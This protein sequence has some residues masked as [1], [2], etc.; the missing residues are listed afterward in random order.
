MKKNEIVVGGTY[1]AKVGKNVTTVRV[2]AIRT[3]SG[4]PLLGP[5][6]GR[7]P[8]DVMLYRVTNLATN[9]KTTFR[10]AAKFRSAAPGKGAQNGKPAQPPAQDVLKEEDKLPPD[11]HQMCEDCVDGEVDGVRCQVCGG[12]G[13]VETQANIDAAYV[14]A[15]GEKRSDP[16]LPVAQSAD[17]SDMS[18]S[19]TNGLTPPSGESKKSAN[20]IASGSSASSTTPACLEA[21]SP[22][23]RPSSETA[24]TQ[25][26]TGAGA[27]IA[28]AHEKPTE[29]Q[30][31]V[32]PAQAANSLA[33]RLAASRAPS[34]AD[35]APHLIVEARAGCLSADTVININRAKKGS[36]MTIEKVVRQFTGVGAT[37][38]RSDNGAESRM[39]PWDVSI[40]TMVARAVGGVVRLG[41]IENAWFSGDKETYALTTDTGRSIH[42]TSIHPFLTQD[43]DWKKL[44]DIV[45]G[46]VLQVNVGRSKKGPGP[47]TYY[48]TLRTQ[49]HPSQTYRGNNVF[50]VPIHRA[51]VEADM[52]TLTLK[53]FAWIVKHD[54]GRSAELTYLPTTSI[55]HHKN[56]DTMDN[57]L[58][59]LE[60]LDS[61]KAHSDEH[62]WGNNVLWQIGFETVLSVEYFGVE[63]TYDIEVSDDP[64]NFL[65]NGF[66]VHNTGKTT[67]LIEGL[68]YVMGGTST[69]MPSPQQE[70]VWKEMARSAGKARSVCF[71]AF[72]KSIA[73][74]L[75]RRVPAGVEAMTMHSLGF[76]AVRQA[77]S[78]VSA[79][80]AEWAVKDRTAA[81]MGGN[82]KDLRRHKFQV[83]RLVEELVGLC[84]VNL[85]DG[86]QED[87]AALLD[88][89][90]L[91]TDGVRSMNEVFNL[92]PRVLD[93]CRSP[94][95]DGR[96]DFDDMV[97][98]PVV[99]GLSVKRYDLLLVD[100]RQDL[101]KCQMSLAL[102]S[103]RRIVAVGDKS[104][105]IYG[106]AGSDVNACENFVQMLKSHGNGEVLQLPLTVTRRCGRAIV[107]EARKIVPD[108]EAHESN[109]AGVVSEARYPTDKD[110]KERPGPH[111][112][113][114]VQDGDMVICRVNA[115]L[116]SQCFRFLKAGRKANI[117]GRDVGQGLVSTV[118][119]LEAQSVLDLIS[120]ID[121][122]LTDESAREHAKKQPRESKLIG[123]QDRR[124]CLLAF[125][126]GA[127]TVEAVIAKI[128]A[129]F[130]DDKSKPGI[131]L[132][133]IHRA[134]GL[135][136]HR[137]FFLMPEGASCPHPLAKTEWARGQERNLLYVGVTR[138][139]NEL[140]YVY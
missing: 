21:S 113:E 49:F 39:R 56:G 3:V 96:I 15:E 140:V 37:Y 9:R 84:K 81:I 50:S 127:A 63:P 104:Q 132:S 139:I 45:P 91:D 13:W 137:V 86:S 93:A 102:M 25:K 16:T 125:T 22:K 121:H 83:F 51:M 80:G 59:N 35:D 89:Y 72:N 47:K 123:L 11:S 64:H 111:Y 26:T 112:T 73:G 14:E 46:D 60:V 58:S 136:A 135:E 4:G 24:P 43:G 109:P 97:W 110:G 61:V 8:S 27:A 10:S 17:T 117:Q 82:F 130:T 66:V 116:V 34:P 106:F 7:T 118:K 18:A 31:T 101:N 19:T 32:L 48:K 67:T 57:T 119:K 44:G 41:R 126:E 33:A 1:L 68:R 71:V 77:F 30:S 115:P 114:R 69:L 95:K 23:I 128:E 138:A 94:E 28:A 99:L 134:K 53:Q 76:K 98:L 122:W 85:K 74:E 75:Q 38:V 5:V 90:D 120:K 42:A 12:S 62:E 36:Q 87:L 103:G 105:S 124:D 107:A 65:A 88:H 131:R 2:D 20:R 55:V 54:R 129:V 133:S 78:R 79:N 52:N 29:R 100:E 6:F 92:V 40:P 70:A 108:F